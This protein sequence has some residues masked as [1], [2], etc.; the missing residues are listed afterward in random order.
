M[1]KKLII[2]DGNSMLYR[3]F[4]A[5][6]LLTTSKGEFSNAIYGYASEMIKVVTSL[7]P[8]HLIVAFDAGR[9]TFRNEIFA[10]YKGTRK[11]MPEELVAQVEPVKEMLRLMGV[12]VIDQSGIEADDI[13]GTLAKRFKVD[14]I[15][16]TG[17]RD[18]FQL[19]DAY[20]KIGFTKHGVSDIKYYT[21]DNLKSEYG[22]NPWEVVDLKALQ[23]DASD[24]I[25]GVSGVGPKT[26]VDLICKF[27]TLDGVY[28]HI[29]EIS[30]K[31]KERL[32]ENKDVAYMSR[33]LAQIKLDADIDCSLEETEVKF[34]FSRELKKFFE[35]Y[36]L[37]SLIKKEELF[38]AEGDESAQPLKQSKN[39]TEI[40]N[41]DE[42]LAF[43]NKV[44][45]VF[46]FFVD[47]FGTVHMAYDRGLEYVCKPKQNLL[48]NSPAEEEILE[49]LQS[50]FEDKNIVKVFY[51][52]KSVMH[53]L[54]GI[55]GGKIFNA[56][57]CGIAVNLLEG[58][59][60]KSSADL[61]MR[62]GFGE[63]SVA[64]ALIE[65]YVELKQKIEEAGATKAYYEIE[66]PLTYTLFNMERRGFKA[67]KDKLLSLKNEYAR[68]MD[69]LVKQ[70]YEAVGHEFNI[71]SPKQLADVLFNEL[72]L[73]K[74]RKGSTS[75]DVLVELAP[76]NNVVPLIIEYRK[77]AKFY[78]TYLAG[79]EQ[80]LD[81]DG[82]VHTK[83]NQMLTATGRLSSSD[84]NLQ[85]VPIR[86]DEGREIRSIFTAS[87]ENNVL[88][89]ADY[90][91][92]ELRILAHLAHDK[93]FIEA[94]NNN[95]DIHTKTA[96]EVFH[97]SP[98]M[99]DGRMRRVAKVVNFGII[100]G[101]SEFGLST[102]LKTSYGEAKKL[103][104]KFYEM[105]PDF[106]NY[107]DNEVK[108]AKEKGYVKTMFGRRRFLPELKAS[109]FMVRQRAE[110][111][112]QNSG[113]QGT[114]AEVIKIAMTNIEKRLTEQGFKAKLIMQVH[115]ELIIDCPKT[116][117]DAVVKM[118]KAEM[119]GAVK[120]DVPLV[121]DVEMAYRW[122]EAH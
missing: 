86:N 53:K 18:S 74:N 122:G 87:S 50:V 63:E 30:G 1:D 85:N 27:G 15:I 48:S 109:Q 55:N 19:I 56:F 71:N 42:F 9:V 105:H 112:A 77:V 121:T 14:K 114:A 103:I 58:T 90:S 118:V 82:Y 117:V 6:P 51:D 67:D 102:D 80:Y 92:I 33:E 93:F 64:T 106:V 65:M 57:D 113:I 36:E 81:R 24:N 119:N 107:M 3:V 7:K 25:P 60:I 16:L 45:D 94:F 69:L 40:T 29:D 37:R 78:G 10:E 89:D 84:P 96:C 97:V 28:A 68:Q 49:K 101:I 72:K 34:P 2:I 17:D 100:Y 21:E 54:A 62:F 12:K 47:E 75:A 61:L 41:I 108:T 35:H 66:M 8:T 44:K 95:E 22:V 5:M 98:D 99:V 52:A 79:L 46:A 43:L 91:Q 73:P 70:I 104:D 110:R 115:D 59:T 116:E 23:G 88:I 39:I 76:Y 38:N 31:L 83:F 20:T 120:L 13:I 4:Y 32:V 111:M 11:P 26:A